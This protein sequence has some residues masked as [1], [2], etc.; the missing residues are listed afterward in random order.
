MRK[1]QYYFIST[2]LWA[3]SVLHQ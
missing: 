1:D 2:Y 3:I